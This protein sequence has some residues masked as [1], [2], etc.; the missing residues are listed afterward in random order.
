M[1]KRKR[2][3]KQTLFGLFCGLQ[4]EKQGCYFLKIKKK[5]GLRFLTHRLDHLDRLDDEK[6]DEQVDLNI[7]TPQAGL[8]EL[9]ETRYYQ[10]T[11]HVQ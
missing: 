9:L 7:L 10:Y 5:V 8:L 11:Y 4:H 2:D 6:E 1:N 3:V